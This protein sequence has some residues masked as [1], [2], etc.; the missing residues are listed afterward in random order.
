MREILHSFSEQDLEVLLRSELGMIGSDRTLVAMGLGNPHPRGYRTYPRVLG[1][2]VRERN[3]IP[4]EEAIRKMSDFPARRLGLSDRGRI[5]PGLVADLVVLD[6]D[7][8]VD[9]AT[10]SDPHQ[11]SAELVHVLVGGGPV[12]EDGEVT[13][14]RPG[15]IL[16]GP[17]WSER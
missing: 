11:Y 15:R 6:P 4:L 17:G 7:E 2:Y 5:A 8:I 9:Q 1:R 12:L 3:V 14:Q 10:F 16:R 13:G